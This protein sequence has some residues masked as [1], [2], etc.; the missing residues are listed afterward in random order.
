VEVSNYRAVGN[1]CSRNAAVEK[2]YREDTWKNIAE[3]TQ[4]IRKKMVQKYK[5][6]F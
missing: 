4:T 5:V 1:L 2:A 6:E 3:A